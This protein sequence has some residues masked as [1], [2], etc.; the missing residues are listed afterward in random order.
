MN[1]H[2]PLS[3]PDFE[4]G[5]SA[6][7]TTPARVAETRRL[8]R[9]FQ[10]RLNVSLV[11]SAGQAARQFPGKSQQLVFRF[12]LSVFH[13]AVLYSPAPILR[14]DVDGTEPYINREGYQ[15]ETTCPRDP[16]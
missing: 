11:N 9:R 12:T 10:T 13:P 1:P 7:S 8:Q 2:G 5:A 15:E 6:S 3:P 16:F 4:S 14:R